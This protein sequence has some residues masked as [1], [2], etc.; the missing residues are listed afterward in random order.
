[1]EHAEHEGPLNKTRAKWDRKL[2][3]GYYVTWFA[4]NAFLFIAMLMAIGYVGDEVRWERVTE[5]D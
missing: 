1:M 2:V 5:A 3:I 4:I